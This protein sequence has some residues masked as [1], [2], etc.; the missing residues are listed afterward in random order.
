MMAYRK[1]GASVPP[2]AIPWVHVYDDVAGPHKL[3][4]GLVH[5]VMLDKPHMSQTAI[6]AT[7]GLSRRTVC[8]HVRTIREEG[9]QDLPSGTWTPYPFNLANLWNDS[10]AVA[11]L[12]STQRYAMMP[13]GTCWAS[14]ANI[15]ARVGVS[16]RKTRDALRALEY[17]HRVVTRIAKP[18]RTAT[19]SVRHDAINRMLGLDD[20]DVLRW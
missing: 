12:M 20:V 10:I 18:G 7:L 6:A 9:L 4:C 2:W 11:V 16:E 13:S 19:Y 17:R 8:R 5:G 15:G 1:Q 3:T 14:V